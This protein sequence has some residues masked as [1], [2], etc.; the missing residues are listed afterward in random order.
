MQWLPT[1][2]S[3]MSKIQNE[4]KIDSFSKFKIDEDLMKFVFTVNSTSLGSI[5]IHPRGEN[6][7][8]SWSFSDEFHHITNKTFFC[9]VANG[10]QDVIKP[11]KFEIV[12]KVKSNDNKGLIDVTLVTLESGEENFSTD[13]RNLI[14]RFPSWTFPVPLVAKVNAYVF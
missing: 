2:T 8:H 6:D 12:L 9:S 14:K 5:Y 10:L 4:A 3:S 11:L 13:F 7:L 1:R